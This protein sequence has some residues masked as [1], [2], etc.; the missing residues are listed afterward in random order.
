MH[1]L[2]GPN[3]FCTA[4]HHKRYCV[5]CTGRVPQFTASTYKHVSVHERMCVEREREK[6]RERDL[7]RERKRVQFSSSGAKLYI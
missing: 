4:S 2:E 5:V 1:L 3:C 6:E 7:E